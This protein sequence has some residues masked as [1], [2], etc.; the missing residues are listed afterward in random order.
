MDVLACPKLL[1]VGEADVQPSGNSGRYGI[2][3]GKEIGAAAQPV[4]QGTGVEVFDA[5]D[6][7]DCHC[8]GGPFLDVKRTV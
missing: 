7:Y 8:L 5:T 2:L 6:A 4:P 3:K 1:E